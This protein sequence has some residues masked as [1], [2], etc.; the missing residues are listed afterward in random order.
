[1]PAKN[2]QS[3]SAADRGVK[4]ALVPQSLEDRD[5]E[6][7]AVLVPEA[8][9]RHLHRRNNRTRAPMMMFEEDL[10]DEAVEEERLNLGIVD[11]VEEGRI[12]EDEVEEEFDE[13]FI[14]QMMTGEG[15]EGFEDIY[16]GD[17]FD[18]EAKHRRMG[19]DAMYAKY[20][21]HD[22]R[23]AGEKQFDKMMAE[24][25]MDE[26]IHEADPRTHGAMTIQNY[27]G[28]LQQFAAEN[29][30]STIMG[31]DP[32][33]HRGYIKQ[34]DI[35]ARN[36]DA[37]SMPERQVLTVTDR[38][39]REIDGFFED[40]DAMRRDLVDALRKRLVDE[41]TLS[42]AAEVQAEIDMHMRPDGSIAKADAAHAKA[43]LPDFVR[44]VMDAVERRSE[45]VDCE[46]VLTTLTSVF[47]L[48]NVISVDAKK[49][50][51]VPKASS[52]EYAARS[53][54]NGKKMA[55]RENNNN[56]NLN[57]ND[58]PL[59]NS[60]SDD[61]EL[62]DGMD[63]GEEAMMEEVLKQQRIALSTV[64]EDETPEQKKHRKALVKQMQRE[65]RQV[66][67]QVK[68]EFAKTGRDQTQTNLKSTR[69]KNTATLS[70]I[71]GNMLV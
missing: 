16:D 40:A 6:G 70:S 12:F 62:N 41:R 44:E 11:D 9:I 3:G 38:R 67:K 30:G 71:R 69:D 8:Q 55:Q 15:V 19:L 31:E 27:A 22:E 66:K 32:Q 24:F 37:L 45:R 21:K 34:L 51:K 54:V 28:E 50:L 18:D 26:D 63:L 52:A 20:P 35:M 13:N 1:M 10:P 59:N 47:N 42:V 48:P 53:A 57:D 58:D 39:E 7:K 23:G 2:K 56:N 14:R 4:F 64:P 65:A 36:N 33:R 60:A 61:D 46:T 17:D 5:F 25:D 43:T 29:A 49:K 68:E